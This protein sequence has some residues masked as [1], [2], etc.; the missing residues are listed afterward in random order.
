[1]NKEL[2][3]IEYLKKKGY[4]TILPSEQKT[5]NNDIV[6]LV[7]QKIRILVGLF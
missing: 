4:T 2:K 7:L 3:M 5:A 1:M 6:H